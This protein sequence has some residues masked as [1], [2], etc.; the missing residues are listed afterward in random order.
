MKTQRSI[1]KRQSFEGSLLGLVF[2]LLLVVMQ[3]CS[4][5]ISPNEATLDT[6]AATVNTLAASDANTTGAEKSQDAGDDDDDHS[7]QDDPN[8][9]PIGS[10][11]DD[12]G[13]DDGTL[14]GDYPDPNRPGNVIICHVSADGAPQSLS[15]LPSQV[16]AFAANSNN[17]DGPCTEE[18]K[19]D[20]SATDQ[21][22]NDQDDPNATPVGNNDDDDDGS[23]L[24]NGRGP[25]GS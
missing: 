14:D 2:V 18:N 3:A 7:D 6:E 17:Y 12:G 21:G 23:D 10:D 8:A 22:G 5:P 19:G 9:T 16:A 24:N 11:D 20:G 25:S 13:D 15:I 1:S 4:D